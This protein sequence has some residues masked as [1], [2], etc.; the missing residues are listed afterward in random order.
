MHYSDMKLKKLI[1]MYLEEQYLYEGLE[2]THTA[3]STLDFL[4]R[5]ISSKCEYGVGVNNRIHIDV[6]HIFEE[7]WNK[8][9]KF[10]NNMGWTPSAYN[11]DLS[12]HRYIKKY[13]TP[14]FLE[15][16]KIYP[17]IR[18]FFDAKYNIEIPQHELPNE[19][20]HLTSA[21]Y[22]EKIMKIGL[23]PKSK[24]KMATHSYRIYLAYDKQ[25]INI[26]LKHP[27]FY[28]DD[29][30]FVILSVDMKMLKNR[31]QIRFF[32]DPEFMDYGVYTYENIPPEFLKQDSVITRK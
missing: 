23:A 18:V 28:P 8:I 10:M 5:W 30:E 24:E 26:L 22:F 6:S 17:F 16:N 27:K 7:E 29:K 12:S 20:Y 31:K 3:E 15:D 19:L 13:N 32:Q 4:G 9:L 2:I 21:K 1:P 14:E 11:R 25:G